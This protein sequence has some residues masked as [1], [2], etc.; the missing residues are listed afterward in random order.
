MLPTFIVIGAMK[1]GTTALYRYLAAHPDVFMSERKELDFFLDRGTWRLGR[2]W[3][4]RQFA[5]A[6]DAAARGEASPN[7]TKVHTMPEPAERMAAMLP[8]ARL[9]YLMRHPI[10]RLQSMY[11]HQLADRQ[12]RR[13]IAEAVRANRDYVRT[14][15]YGMQVANYLRH[16]RREQLLLLKSEDLRDDRRAALAR[17]YEF[18]GVDPGF[19][20]ADVADEP[21]RAAGRRFPNAAGAVLLGLPAY[22]RMVERSWRAR[23]VHDRLL[24][25]EHAPA[26]AELPPDL[27][28]E[29]TEVFAPDLG[30]LRK[31]MP[32][33]FDGWGLG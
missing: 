17:V 2:D 26:A 6:G 21:N 23:E 25:T 4:E 14:S 28:D 18:V 13:P 3:Y 9:V 11:L 33:D 22:R 10:E 19:V 31:W 24:T 16:F 7:Y 1:A 30:R 29:L 27:R 12:E 20:P 8:D 15:M 5:A 32:A